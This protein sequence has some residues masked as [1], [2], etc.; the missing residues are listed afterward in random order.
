MLPKTIESYGAPWQDKEAATDP[1]TE[2]AADQANRM[3]ED[4]AQGTRTLTRAMVR[5][6]T[7]TA[8]PGPIAL[9]RAESVWGSSVATDP[10]VAKIAT[11]TY[12]ITYAASYDDALVG[13]V[14]DAVAETELV[15][16]N[17]AWGC[18]VGLQLAFVQAEGANNVVTAYVFDLAGALSDLGGARPIQVFMR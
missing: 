11:G 16:F 15:S 7:S 9:T 8:A 6:S 13:T 18:G 12:T 5:F 2:Q 14:S 17:F 4:L 3:A 10:V 1:Q